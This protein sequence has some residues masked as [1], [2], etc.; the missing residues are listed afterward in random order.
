MP[1]SNPNYL[2]LDEIGTQ[3]TMVVK[4]RG[5]EHKLREATV[6][7]FIA[8]TRESQRLAK[9]AKTPDEELEAILNMILRAFPTLTRTDLGGVSMS[10]LNKLLASAFAMNGQDAGIQAQAE[11]AKEKNPA[12]E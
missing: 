4:I 6:D 10:N 3:D 9:D 2:D 8:N 5:R 1:Q 12:G 11:V 7:D